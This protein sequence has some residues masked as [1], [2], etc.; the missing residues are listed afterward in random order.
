MPAPVQTVPFPS[1]ACPVVRDTKEASIT[2]YVGAFL[3][4]G[5]SDALIT[6]AHIL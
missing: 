2:E 3:S 4:D 5:L 1:D 6:Y